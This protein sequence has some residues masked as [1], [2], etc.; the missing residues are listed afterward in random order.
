MPGRR[1]ALLLAAAIALCVQSQCPYE[2]FAWVGSSVIADENQYS[3]LPWEKVTTVGMEPSLIFLFLSNA[4]A[5][6]FMEHIVG[7]FGD[8]NENFRDYVHSLGK[9]LVMAAS[10]SKID[11]DNET[12]VFMSCLIFSCLFG[13]N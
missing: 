5:Q 10:P 4:I 3:L 12:Q 6:H 2:V 11:M 13:Y 9:S 1:L 7:F 8:A